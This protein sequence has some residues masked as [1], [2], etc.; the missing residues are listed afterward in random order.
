MDWRQRRVECQVE[1]SH[2]DT[3]NQLLVRVFGGQ[4][5]PPA[6]FLGIVFAFQYAES[7]CAHSDYTTRAFKEFST[8]VIV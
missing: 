6:F 8:A 3:Q 2:T 5:E 1:F 7:V 4:T